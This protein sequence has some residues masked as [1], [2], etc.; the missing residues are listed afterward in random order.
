MGGKV[1]LLMYFDMIKSML[2]RCTQECVIYKKNAD[3]YICKATQTKSSCIQ[4][5]SGKKTKIG[6]FFSEL[7]F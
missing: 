4:V 2:D 5:S 3:Q 6:F 1:N 7:Y